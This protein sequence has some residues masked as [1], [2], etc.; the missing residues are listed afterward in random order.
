MS[1]ITLVD[2]D[3]THPGT[4][5]CP[6]CRR[7]MTIDLAMFNNNVAKIVESNCPYCNGKIFSCIIV[8]ANVTLPLLVNQ[9]Q[10]IVSAAGGTE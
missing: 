1:Q 9:I 10:R 4:M 3:D 5:V 8:M 2:R 6:R 7:R